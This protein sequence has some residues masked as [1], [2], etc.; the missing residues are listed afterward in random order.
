MELMEC[1]NVINGNIYCI[2]KTMNLMIL[3]LK[4]FFKLFIQGK[5]MSKM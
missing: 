5:K 1:K 2:F 3:Y 4:K